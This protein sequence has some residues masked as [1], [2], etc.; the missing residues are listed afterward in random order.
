MPVKAVCQGENSQNTISIPTRNDDVSVD[1]TTNGLIH[2]P[3]L[4]YCVFL[5]ESESCSPTGLLKFILSI[6]FIDNNVYNV[7]IQQKGV[8]MMK[9]NLMCMCRMCMCW[10]AS[11]PLCVYK[12]N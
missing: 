9:L 6:D 1:S 7:P 5:E 12:R 3:F 8:A 11:C 2:L 10:P 4:S